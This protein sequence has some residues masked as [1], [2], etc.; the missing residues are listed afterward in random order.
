MIVRARF[1]L[2]KKLAAPSNSVAPSPPASEAGPRVRS[3]KESPVRTRRGL[4]PLA[5]GYLEAN[6]LGGFLRGLMWF[7]GLFLA[8]VLVSGAQKV[9]QHKM[10]IGLLVQFIALQIPRIVVFTIPSSLLFGSVSTFTE[11]SSRGEITALMAGGMSIRRMLRA[12]LVAAIALAITAFWLQESIVPQ[13][14]LKRGTLAVS[15]LQNAKASQVFPIIDKGDNGRVDRIIWASDFDAKNVVL[16]NPDIRINQEDGTSIHITAKSARWDKMRGEWVFVQG[17][18]TNEPAPGKKG[19]ARLEF[20]EQSFRAEMSLDPASLSK[21]ARDLPAQLA[22]HNFEMVSLA[23]LRTYRND[24]IERIHR[25]QNEFADVQKI[26]QISPK[27]TEFFQKKIQFLKS[28]SR[29]ATFGIHD[30]WATPLVVFA[31][32]LIGAPLGVR[33]QRTASSGL[34]LGMSLMVLLGYYIGWTLTSQWGKGGGGQPL[35]A[36][37]L[38]FITLA[39]LGAFLTWKK[40]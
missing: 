12:P 4:W 31:M 24:M 1:I 33:P 16:L 7:V 17:E 10:D 28:E 6:V 2:V 30:K 34:A 8:F 19:F 37:Y 5:D 26:G 9:A 35:L 20:A 32:V 3:F 23:E 27:Q 11:M 40:S 25:T 29:A 38:P 21:S 13:C 22:D 18:T 14:E 36:A 39:S 15:A